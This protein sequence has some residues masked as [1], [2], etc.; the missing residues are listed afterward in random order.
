MNT[1]TQMV[2]KEINL[3]VNEQANASLQHIQGQ[4]AYMTPEIF[5]FTLKLFIAIKNKDVQRKLDASSCLVLVSCILT[6]DRSIQKKEETGIV[7]SG[8]ILFQ[9]RSDSLELC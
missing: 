6:V 4:L 1:Y 2:I 8:N 7:I 3:Q 9:R 5:T